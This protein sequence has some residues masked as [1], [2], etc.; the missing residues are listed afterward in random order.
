MRVGGISITSWHPISSLLHKHLSTP[1]ALQLEFPVLVHASDLTHRKA[2]MP[3]LFHFR[4]T[5]GLL[6]ESMRD[7]YYILTSRQF[8]LAQIF[9][10]TASVQPKFP[11]P[12]SCEHG[13]RRSR[14]PKPAPVLGSPTQKKTSNQVLVTSFHTISNRL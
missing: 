8:S 10:L 13:N 6:R 7:K 12:I 5:S 4:G 1:L 9:F 2:P 14:P 3:D 11:C